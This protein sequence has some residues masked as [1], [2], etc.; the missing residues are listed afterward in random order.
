[1]INNWHRLRKS[2]SA[3]TPAVLGMRSSRFSSPKQPSPNLR[4]GLDVV[5]CLLI[6]DFSIDFEID[7]HERRRS[8]LDNLSRQLGPILSSLLQENLHLP[9]NVNPDLLDWICDRATTLALQRVAS[10]SEITSCQPHANMVSNRHPEE[11]YPAGP[12]SLAPFGTNMPQ[13]QG[14]LMF[15][16]QHP[17]NQGYPV[18]FRPGGGIAPHSYYSNMV[19]TDQDIPG[20]CSFLL[21]EQNDAGVPG[22]ICDIDFNQVHNQVG[23]DFSQWENPL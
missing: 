13:S 12:H 20:G 17:S 5:T 3:R 10:G 2:D 19:P 6:T 8:L 22:A 11:I 18:S 15:H 21:P 1:M 4:V 9:V 16:N 7:G 23:L 14:G